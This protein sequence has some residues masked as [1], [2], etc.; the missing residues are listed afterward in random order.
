MIIGNTS[1]AQVFWTEDYTSA[2][3]SLCT[4]PFTSPN[5]TW[6]MVSTGTNGTSANTWFVS[7]TES[8]LG[9]GACGTSGSDA[10]LHIAN[11]ST[12]PA[13]SLFCPTGDCGAAY[14]AGDGATIVSNQRATSPVINCTGKTNIT[15][16]FNYMMGGFAG[17]DYASVCYFNGATWTTLVSPPIT[18]LCG[19]QGKWTYYSVA[20]PAS[21]NNN[22][23]V[24]IGFNWQNTATAAGVDPSVAIDSVTLSSTA[25]PVANFSGTPL[26]ICAGQS[27]SFTDLSTNSPTSWSWT[28]AGGTPN[29]ST[30]QNPVVV[31]NTPG[32]YNVSLTATNGSGS[33]TLTKTGY[34]IVNASPTAVI[35]PSSATIC[36]GKTITLTASGG[37]A[38]TW[39]TGASTAV[40]TVSPTTTTTYSVAVSNGTCFST[41]S[42]TVTVNPSP[43]GTVTGDTS[44][45]Q[46]AIT[47]LIASGGT[48]YIWN[49][50]ATTPSINVTPFTTTNY[51]V[52]ISNGSC[53]DSINTKISVYPIPVPTVSSNTVSCSG[54]PVQLTAGGGTTYSWSPAA[55]LSSTTIANPIATPATTTIYTVTV[56]NGNCFVKDSVTVKSE[57]APFVEVG[58]VGE[59]AGVEDTTI[60]I[61]E[62]VQ[63]IATGGVNFLWTPSAGLDCNTCQNPKANPMA[64]TFYVA[65][66][67]DSNG[68]T[69]FDT[70]LVKVDVNCGQL[71]V[72]NA[73][74][75][76][77]DGENDV[78][79]VR[80]NCL[81]SMDFLIFDRWGEKVFESTDPRIGWDG[82]YK[83]KPMN[84]A[85][86]SYYVKATLVNYKI[87][88][89]RGNVALLR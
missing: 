17:S 9:R 77:G 47:T 16:A 35:T 89:Q 38:Y 80:G 42:A 61:G 14:D 26:T 10:S 25:I 83:G 52:L 40:I 15:L 46:G 49:T 12:S 18:A 74:S 67:S 50:G 48:N 44:I 82:T 32:T 75:P 4:L 23:S 41:T 36:S 37:S 13:A 78:L 11:V 51:W 71:F 2:C 60:N 31:Y 68:C 88:E 28:F 62:T 24:Q 86:F 45:C 73:F 7:E 53:Y 43:V 79:Y 65:M 64:S 63:L 58:I 72:P 33:N 20:L 34:V 27:V 3:V 6:T 81:L 54:A 76:N 22:P 87:V 84:T 55:G 85:V 29:S 66:I 1:F 5:G 70:I 69:A 56:S 30:L 59:K 19:V 57:P 39:S 8:G 21:A